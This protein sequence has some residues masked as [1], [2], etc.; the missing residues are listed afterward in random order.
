MAGAAQPGAAH[1]IMPAVQQDMKRAGERSC[2]KPAGKHF[3]A[4][5]TSC[6]MSGGW[7]SALISLVEGRKTYDQ[8]H[9]IPSEVDV[10]AMAALAQE[11][12]LKTHTHWWFP[13]AS[14]LPVSKP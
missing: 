10:G 12:S 8:N 6:H 7:P 9:T 3:N 14:P 2:G 13:A 11:P 5:A 1:C 4:Q